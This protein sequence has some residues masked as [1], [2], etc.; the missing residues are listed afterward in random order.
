MEKKKD[1]SIPIQ[2]DKHGP[3]WWST[4]PS[5]KGFI[6]NV[7]HNGNIVVETILF[8]YIIL[9]GLFTTPANKK[10]RHVPIFFIGWGVGFEI[11][12]NCLQMTKKVI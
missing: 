10:N 5:R 12:Q 2:R 6:C 4:N 1:L 9:V 11:H 8:G 3:L 7:P